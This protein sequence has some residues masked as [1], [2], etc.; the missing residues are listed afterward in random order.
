MAGRESERIGGGIVGERV[1]QVGAIAQPADKGHTMP[2]RSERPFDRQLDGRG[3]I[4]RLD[5]KSVFAGNVS[6]LEPLSPEWR[7]RRERLRFPG[8]QCPRG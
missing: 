3:S 1:F 5:L 2:A 7:A 4:P 6:E 8:L